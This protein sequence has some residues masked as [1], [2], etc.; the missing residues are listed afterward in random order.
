MTAGSQKVYEEHLVRVK[1]DAARQ[2]QLNGERVFL[3]AR[4]GQRVLRT[5]FGTD[6][7]GFDVT[8]SRFDGETRHFDR[9]SQPIEEIIEARIWAG[10]QHYRTA[11][12]QALM[13]AEKI[14]DHMD[15]NYFQPAD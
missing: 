15:N 2:N 5:F 10:L 14:V 12:V 7:I 4:L 6:E 11:D 9:F 1:G 3:A 8:S 13:Q